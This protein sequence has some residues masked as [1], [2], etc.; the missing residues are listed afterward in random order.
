MGPRL[1]LEPAGVGSRGLQVS[2]AGWLSSLAASATEPERGPQ[3]AASVDPQP[4]VPLL[5]A[6]ANDAAQFAELYTQSELTR[7][8]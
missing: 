4:W 3:Q 8:A 5:H 2:G 6:D 1:K 7:R